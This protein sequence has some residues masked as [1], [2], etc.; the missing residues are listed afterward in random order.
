MLIFGLSLKQLKNDTD[1]FNNHKQMDQHII[2]I[3]RI[4]Q[5][6]KELK[7]IQYLKNK[8]LQI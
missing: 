1:Q 2:K 5:R 6:R 8:I 7:I 3:S 4:N